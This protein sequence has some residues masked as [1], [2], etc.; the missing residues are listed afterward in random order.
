MKV[1][2]ALLF[3]MLM[4]LELDQLLLVMLMVLELSMLVL[5]IV[6]V[7]FIVLVMLIIFVVLVLAV[8]VLV[9]VLMSRKEAMMR[10]TCP[11]GV[12][13]GNP[14]HSPTTQQTY[15]M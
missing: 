15:A 7:I 5:S 10:S 13:Y 1:E 4:V 6:L 12:T 2:D 14:K 11:P 3:V 9:V 8:L